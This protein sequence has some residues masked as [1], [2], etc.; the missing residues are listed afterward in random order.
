MSTPSRLAVRLLALDP[1]QE[2][3]HRTL[4][5]LY[6]RQGR[7]GPRSSN[8]RCAWACCGES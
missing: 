1:L 2:A 3:V 8:T 7:R 6:G 4:M 5:R